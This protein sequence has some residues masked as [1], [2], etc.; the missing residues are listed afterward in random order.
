MTQLT[1]KR[2]WK[3]IF[4]TKLR[5]SAN[6]S[7]AARAAGYSRQW[8]Y[9]LRADDPEFAAEWDN[10]IEESMDTAEG[11][12]YRRAVNGV[13]R[14]VFYKGVEIDRVREYS[15]SLLMFMA[16]AYRPERY[17]EVTKTELNHTGE[18]NQKLSG[19]IGINLIDYRANL[20]DN[21]DA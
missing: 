5:K 9:K 17:K 20:Q 11:E 10:A 1:A 4:L 13:V 3:E 12:I 19:D 18:I 16:K 14:R 7:A 2:E 21:A 15:D 8:A 6:V